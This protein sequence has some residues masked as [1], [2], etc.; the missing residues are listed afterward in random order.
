M[1]SSLLLIY[2]V[3]VEHSYVQHEDMA[4][5][6]IDLLFQTMPTVESI[7][8]WVL[9]VLSITLIL[10]CLNAVRKVYKTQRQLTQ[11]SV[12]IMLESSKVC[13]YLTSL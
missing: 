11:D 4:K 13:P 7:R 9:I 1:S 6:H 5:G 12:L 3:D 8:Q 10:M 2:P